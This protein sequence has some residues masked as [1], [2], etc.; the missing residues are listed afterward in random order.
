MQVLD[1]FLILAIASVTLIS[2]AVFSHQFKANKRKKTLLELSNRRCDIYQA[3]EELDNLL[4]NDRYVERRTIDLWVKKWSFLFP[5]LKDLKKHKIV[6][7][8]LNEKTAMLFKMFEKTYEG[9]AVRN[10]A[11]IEQETKRCEWLFN[12]IEKY[13]LTKSQIRSIITDEYAN[14]VIAGAGTGKTSTIVG[15]AAASSSSRAASSKSVNYHYK[16]VQTAL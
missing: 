3:H 6:D 11:F 2:V 4:G 9:I 10:E 7:T 14:L 15:K 12:S 5:L 1:F 8:D 16:K 13:P